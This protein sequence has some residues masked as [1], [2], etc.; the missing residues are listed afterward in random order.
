[1]P[2]VPGVFIKWYHE[3]KKTGF[4]D[5]CWFVIY[6]R[7]NEFSWKLRLSQ[8][9]LKPPDITNNNAYE[10][11]IVARLRAH[12]INESLEEIKCF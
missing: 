4:N 3:I 1:M 5:W 7:R 11:L 6:L 9:I 10:K 12:R 8:R 2:F